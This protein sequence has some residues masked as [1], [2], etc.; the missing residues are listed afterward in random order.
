MFATHVPMTYTKYK[1]ETLRLPSV[2]SKKRNNT[3]TA[4]YRLYTKVPQVIIKIGN[5]E[6]I[7]T[8]LTLGRQLTACVIIGLH[9]FVT[10]TPY[11][12]GPL[13]LTYNVHCH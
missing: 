3:T 2:N 12:N 7:G 9:K 6:F 4:T 1:H 5:I 11:I 13:Q 8:M 10:I